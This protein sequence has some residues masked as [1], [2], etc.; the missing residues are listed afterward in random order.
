[1]TLGAVVGT[2]GAAPL[3]LDFQTDALAG[4]ITAGQVI[5]DEFAAYGITISA[6]NGNASRPD[7]AIA[8]DSANPTGGDPDLATPGP[9][10]GNDTALGN[11]LIIA[12]DV[13]DT[14]PA[15]GLIDDPDD[16]RAGG[17]LKFTFDVMQT[18]SGSVTLVDVEE[19]GGTIEFLQGG[20]VVGA[21]TLGI[22]NLNNNSVQ[23][24]AFD[25][26]PFDALH[27]N[28]AGSGAVGAIELSDHD[29]PEPAS[30][31]IAGAGLV[32]I[33]GRRRRRGRA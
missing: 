22:P 30:L 28:L 29:V 5:D 24:V 20:S 25:T 18:A 33:A 17:T 1:M 19:A 9:G 11:L 6:V 32:L 27:V 4:T 14:S 26:R 31:A 10:T 3:V 8:F 23:T 2:A 21:L 12:E 13:V 15:D 7:V 16:E